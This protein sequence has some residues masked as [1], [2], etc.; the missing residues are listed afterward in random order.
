MLKAMAFLNLSTKNSNR[1]RKNYLAMIRSRSVNK[2]SFSVTYLWSS[3]K[4]KHDKILQISQWFLIK[5][6]PPISILFALLSYRVYKVIRVK[7]FF[8]HFDK[9]VIDKWTDL[10]HFS[11]QITSNLVKKA[12][13]CMS[14]RLHTR[15][16]R[17]TM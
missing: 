12:I 9:N 10:S 15:K 7:I 6:C 5:R 11:Y 16:S 3:F 1:G 13:G 14:Q 4:A 2:F 8:P 17:D